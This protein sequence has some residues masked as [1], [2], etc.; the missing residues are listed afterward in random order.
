M[1]RLKVN[2]KKDVK[3]R[4]T[5]KFAVNPNS[6]RQKALREKAAK[7]AAS[8]GYSPAPDAFTAQPVGQ[9]A[10]TPVTAP[11]DGRNEGE[12][13]GHRVDRENHGGTVDDAP[14]TVD[15][16]EADN[17]EAEATTETATGANPI[18]SY[19]T[20][21]TGQPPNSPPPAGNPEVLEPETADTSERPKKKKRNAQE[22]KFFSTM[23][24]NGIGDIWQLYFNMRHAPWFEQLDS[25]APGVDELA[26]MGTLAESEKAMIASALR[27][28]I[29][30]SD[31]EMSPGAELAGVLVLAFLPRFLALEG[32]RIA[33]LREMKKKN[34]AV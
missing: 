20:P 25:K 12:N 2:P 8:S 24:A 34:S 7:M 31:F 17:D 26:E 14:V 30:D 29:A 15:R 18:D 4:K 13:H 5:G 23:A 22:D 6:K 21:P 11:Q 16:D 33:I 10:E 3:D 9:P 27:A 28:Y 32:T 19:F 1:A